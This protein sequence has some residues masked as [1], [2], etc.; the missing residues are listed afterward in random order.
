MGAL[1]FLLYVNDTANVSERL[2]FI[3]FADDT[4]V[5]YH[6]KDLLSA[7]N[8]INSDLK[9][10]ALWFRINE[11]SLHLGKSNYMLFKLKK[12]TMQILR[13]LLAKQKL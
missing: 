8:F 5:F 13:Y 9:V 3:L 11:L 10:F 6:D 12:L 1:L 2:K 7:Q 4:N